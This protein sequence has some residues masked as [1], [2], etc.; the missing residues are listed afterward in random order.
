MTNETPN[1]KNYRLLEQRFETEKHFIPTN[2]LTDIVIDA[3]GNEL[4]AYTENRIV[5][6]V[7]NENGEVLGF[8]NRG[9]N[10]NGIVNQIKIGNEFITGFENELKNELGIRN[11]N[12]IAEQYGIEPKFRNEVKNEV[13]NE[14]EEL[15]GNE[16]V[17]A[18][19]NEILFYSTDKRFPQK[20][21]LVEKKDHIHIRIVNKTNINYFFKRYRDTV[22]YFLKKEY[23]EP[24]EVED[25]HLATDRLSIISKVSMEMHQ[26][27]I[28]EF[29]YKPVFDD[30]SDECTDDDTE[31]STDY[32]EEL[33][34]LQKIHRFLCGEYPQ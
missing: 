28:H 8:E 3:N 7:R 33:S 18:M 32:E 26:R 20:N 1:E 13:E 25:F 22:N 9:M 14:L 27:E 23:L 2:E 10:G 34:L 29:V 5:Y 21:S 11:E 31:E 30:N 12:E 17:T 6:P 15:I 16:L 19:K 4:Y 24:S